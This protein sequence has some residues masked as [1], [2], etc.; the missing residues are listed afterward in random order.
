MGIFLILLVGFLLVFLEFYLPGA[1]L[2]IMGGILIVLS[3]ILFI[4]QTDSPVEA[5]LFFIG[6]VVALG[7][8]VKFALWKIRRAKPSESIFSDAS[9]VGYRAS[10]LDES[11]YGKEAVALSDLKPGGYIRCHGSQY[12]AISQSGYLV[13]GTEVKIIGGEGESYLVKKKIKDEVV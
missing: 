4:Y 10:S 1:I 12:P 6:I 5:L 8:L 13:R 9:Q 7:F 2:G 11:L 3:L